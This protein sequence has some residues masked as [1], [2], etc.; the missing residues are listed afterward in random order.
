VVL[1]IKH[2][3]KTIREIDVQ[4]QGMYDDLEALSVKQNPNVNKQNQLIQKIQELQR[5]KTSLYTS[6]SNNYATTISNVAVSRNSL[7]NEI[8]VGGIVEHELKNVQG[9]LSALQDARYGKLRMAEINNYYSDKYD[10]QAKVMKSIVYFCIPIL[11]LGLLMKRGILPSNIAL[12][13]I[14][15]I[16]GLAIVVV[17]LQ[18][19]DIASRDNMNFSEYNFP[20]DPTAVD[21]N[22]MGNPNDQPVKVDL[23][24]SCAGE[25]CCPTGNPNGTKWDSAN[26]QCVTEGFVGERCLK[27]SFRKSDFNVGVFTNNSVVSGY[28]SSDNNSDNYAKF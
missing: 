20:F 23:T 2:T 8:A 18:L 28:N 12:I 16:L 1:L 26:K 7:V 4:I 9:N 3:L 17:L 19:F 5:M 10:T 6:V 15:I 21:S 13:L 27:N 24:L 25:A 11:I 14:A 22:D